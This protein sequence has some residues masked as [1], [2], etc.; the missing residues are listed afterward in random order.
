[1]I[2][3]TPALL[4]P[5]WISGDTVAPW[6]AVFVYAFLA[7]LPRLMAWYRCAAPLKSELREACGRE[8]N[9]IMTEERIGGTRVL[10]AKPRNVRH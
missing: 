2:E 10:P 8:P 1:M 3:F 7:A 9:S 4:P 6:M 5:V